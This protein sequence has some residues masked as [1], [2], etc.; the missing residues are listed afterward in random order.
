MKLASLIEI[1][2]LNGVFSDEQFLF[3]P[4]QDERIILGTELSLFEHS[5][6]NIRYQGI[7][8]SSNRLFA[9]FR[10]S[11]IIKYR[12]ETILI[13]P[14]L[15]I[16]RG[17]PEQ[18][19]KNVQNKA[20]YF[21]ELGHEYGRRFLWYQQKHELPFQLETVPIEPSIQVDPAGFPLRQY[22]E[23][24]T[25]FFLHP[26]AMLEDGEAAQF[27]I[28]AFQKRYGA[29]FHFAGR[30]HEDEFRS[31]AFIEGTQATLGQVF[32]LGV[33]WAL[34]RQTIE[35]MLVEAKKNNPQSLYL[36]PA[37]LAYAPNFAQKWPWGE[38]YDGSKPEIALRYARMLR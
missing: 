16:D 17:D 20:D 31:W 4:L 11:G 8:E 30:V 3:V 7:A 9:M 5:Y 36:Y 29:P 12:F 34:N 26:S 23:Q 25:H 28:P 32:L 37:W 38:E 21:F 6:V 15:A 14:E 22:C 2:D 24:N 18:W 33:S 27:F 1:P 13:H 10:H 19:H 35:S